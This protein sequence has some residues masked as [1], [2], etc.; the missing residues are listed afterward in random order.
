MAP[1]NERGRYA[2]MALALESQLSP[3]C[4]KRLNRRSLL[5]ALFRQLSFPLRELGLALQQ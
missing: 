2:D 5:G 3:H 4:R 1:L